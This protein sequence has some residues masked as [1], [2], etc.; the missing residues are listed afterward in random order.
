MPTIDQILTVA[1]GILPLFMEQ[2]IDS[3]LSSQVNTSGKPDTKGMDLI[4]EMYYLGRIQETESGKEDYIILAEEQG[5][6]GTAGKAR[7]YFL[8]PCDMSSSLEVYLREFL[9]DGHSETDKYSDFLTW[10]GEKSKSSPKTIFESPISSITYA[11]RDRIYNVMV[12]LLN[13]DIYCAYF[14]EGKKGTEQKGMFK[15][16]GGKGERI[17]ITAKVNKGG[18]IAANIVGESNYNYNLPKELE[19]SLFIQGVPGPHRILY[20]TELYAETLIGAVASDGERLTEWIGWLAWMAAGLGEKYDLSVWNR[21]DV[22]HSSNSPMAPPYET[23]ILPADGSYLPD[24]TKLR[25][26]S[27]YTLPHAVSFAQARDS[28]GIV[29]KH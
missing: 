18:K 6:L 14:D 11:D 13:G 2:T 15:M 12:N 4:P 27:V 24:I 3:L 21:N 10:M 25:E 22:R 16:L 19:Q 28:F 20:L 26:W 8:D 5:L 1:Q 23:S 17:P 7:G 9:D 29:P